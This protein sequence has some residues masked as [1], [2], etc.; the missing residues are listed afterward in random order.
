MAIDWKSERAGVE[1]LLARFPPESNQCDKL[2]SE[3]LLH[4][5]RV[6]EQA[7]ALRVE[8]TA[9]FLK[10]IR[11]GAPACVVP[12]KRLPMG[13]M[14]QEHWT[15][16]V[17]EHCADALTGADGTLRADYLRTHFQ[18]DDALQLVRRELPATTRQS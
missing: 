14:W 1:N 8:P 10:T 18:Y 9:E 15:T 13:T 5:A 12:W 7:H 11:R 6:D 3:L 4:A 2:C 17:Q 16:A